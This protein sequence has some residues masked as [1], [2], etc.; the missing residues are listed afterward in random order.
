MGHDC[1]IWILHFNYDLSL[2]KTKGH[3]NMFGLSKNASG[4]DLG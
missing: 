3:L 2:N 1:H 4:M